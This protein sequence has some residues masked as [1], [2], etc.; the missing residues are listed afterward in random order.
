MKRVLLA[1]LALSLAPLTT[2]VVPAQAANMVPA[3]HSA[4]VD[5]DGRGDRVT[6]RKVRSNCVVRVATARGRVARVSIASWH[7][8]PCKF[9]GAA[10]ID[11][12]RGKEVVVLT[13]LG[14]HTQWYSVL[15]WRNGRLQRQW[16]DGNERWVADSA[17][18]S[19]AGIKRMRV[20][21]KPA[22]VTH[23]LWR[24]NGTR[25]TGPRKVFRYR[26]GRWVKVGQ[27]HVALTQKQARG[28]SG[29]HVKGL[30]RW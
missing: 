16:L 26:N 21:G 2:T 3:A 8:D 9:R 7:S 30:P 6:V 18:N 24:G 25:F 17:Y 5:G 14:A 28:I 20:G 27:R 29:W 12:R 23:A 19:A 4:D 1:A 10:G 11:T 22:I 15:T 13:Q